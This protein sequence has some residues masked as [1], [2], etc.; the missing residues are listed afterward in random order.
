M[1][2]VLADE[3]QDLTGEVPCRENEISTR[4]QVREHAKERETE[5]LGDEPHGESE[6]VGE[7]LISTVRHPSSHGRN[8]EGHRPNR[9]QTYGQRGS[10]RDPELG[11]TNFHDSL[12]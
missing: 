6:I 11:Y 3:V 4:D 7:R 12:S 1:N 8:R 10:C 9:S 2:G 5:R